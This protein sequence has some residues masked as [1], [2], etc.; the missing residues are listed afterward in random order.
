[1][2]TE[3]MLTFWLEHIRSKV[4]IRTYER[5]TEI[6]EKHLAPAFKNVRLLK[7]RPLHVQQYLGRAEAIYRAVAIFGFRMFGQSHARVQRTDARAHV[8]PPALAH[9]DIEGLVHIGLEGEDLEL[10][11]P[12]LG[13]LRL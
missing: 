9:E 13:G 3:D 7:L 6:V 4:A 11:E 12:D 8:L 5:Y 1:M 10:T 2:T